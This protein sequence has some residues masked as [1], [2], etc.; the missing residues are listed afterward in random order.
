[1][2]EEVVVEVELL[3][4]VCEE[5]VVVEVPGAYKTKYAAAP[6]TMITMTMITATTLEIALREW[7]ISTAAASLLAWLLF[8]ECRGIP[9]GAY[10]EAARGSAPDL[11]QTLR[12]TPLTVGMT[13]FGRKTATTMISRAR[14]KVS[15]VLPGSAL[16]SQ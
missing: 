15:S 14:M 16:V 5:V 6:T 7:L 10:V 11:P 4:V 12:S 3:E 13:P 1:M 2:V 9:K 8:K